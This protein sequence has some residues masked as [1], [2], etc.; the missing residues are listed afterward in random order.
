M[1]RRTD[2]NPRA[3]EPPKDPGTDTGLPPGPAEPPKDPSPDSGLPAGPAEPPKAEQP[4]TETPTGSG[5]P[6]ITAAS[7][8]F[9]E[10]PLGGLSAPQAP[11]GGINAAA[12]DTLEDLINEVLHMS[13]PQAPGPASSDQTSIQSLVS[14]IPAT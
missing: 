3:V 9:S 12:T 14:R 2:H 4:A 7:V 11:R 10:L 13:A 5:S 6:Q 1:G 8:A